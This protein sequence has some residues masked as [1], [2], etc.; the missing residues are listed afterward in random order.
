M[1][2]NALPGRVRPAQ[3][4]NAKPGREPGGA[5]STACGGN[6]KGTGGRGPPLA[7]APMASGPTVTA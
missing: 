6:P 3:G 4:A 1:D 2:A 7:F 5:E